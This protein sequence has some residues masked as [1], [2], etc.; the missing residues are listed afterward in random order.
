MMASSE[1][2]LSGNSAES[3]KN[4]QTDIH[5]DYC[6]GRHHTN[7][8]AERTCLGGCSKSLEVDDST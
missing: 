8:N 4:D 6:I 7:V 5:D 1:E 3:S 2:S